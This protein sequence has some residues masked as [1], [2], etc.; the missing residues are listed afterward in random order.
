MSSSAL[1]QSSEKWG[2]LREI[3]DQRNA[4]KWLPTG[5]VPSDSKCCPLSL[6]STLAFAALPVLFASLA[7]FVV[8]LPFR[9]VQFAS[10]CI[11]R[12]RSP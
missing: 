11:Q 1:E 7:I 5:E 4:M 8:S 10:Q 6:P 9:P 12:L 3:R 2:G